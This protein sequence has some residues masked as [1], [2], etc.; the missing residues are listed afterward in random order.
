MFE[1][2][3]K[4]LSTVRSYRSSYTSYSGITDLDAVRGVDYCVIALF[5]LIFIV[6]GDIILE[7]IE[8]CLL[9]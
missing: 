8:E 6:P 9:L 1:V 4:A 5:S 2:E 7:M 3:F